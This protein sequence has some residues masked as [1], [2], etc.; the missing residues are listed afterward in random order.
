MTTS[1]FKAHTSQIVCLILQHLFFRG[2]HCKRKSTKDHTLAGNNET[3]DQN[4]LSADHHNQPHET[5]GAV[6]YQNDCLLRTPD[7]IQNNADITSGADQEYQ[8]IT[9]LVSPQHHAPDNGVDGYYDEIDQ[10]DVTSLS[11]VSPDVTRYEGLNDVS[12]IPEPDHHY[13]S[14]TGTNTYEDIDDVQIN[15]TSEPSRPIH[16][17]VSGGYI[18]VI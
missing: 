5:R 14:I 17:D 13:T 2:E 16:A 1:L 7:R 15:T 12:R 8:H 18:T 9:N 3:A 6:I 10:S 11:G 4:N